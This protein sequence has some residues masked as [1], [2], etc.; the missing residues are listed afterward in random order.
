MN[1][2]LGKHKDVASSVTALMGYIDKL[3]GLI[4]NLPNKDLSNLESTVLMNLR[5]VDIRNELKKDHGCV[6]HCLDA[7]V[8]DVRHNLS[9]IEEDTDEGKMISETLKEIKFLSAD[10]TEILGPVEFG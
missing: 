4:G 5:W 2:V 8:Y 1:R 3:T 6:S 9:H 7:A 10:L